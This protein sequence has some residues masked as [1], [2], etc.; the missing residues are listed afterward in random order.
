MKKESEGQWIRWP[1]PD[2]RAKEGGE[3]GVRLRS[4]VRVGDGGGDGCRRDAD[5]SAQ[6]GQPDAKHLYLWSKVRPPG[7]AGFY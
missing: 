2:P 4:D 1:A 3:R 7:V 6:G 5:L